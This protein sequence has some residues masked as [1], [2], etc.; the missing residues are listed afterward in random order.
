MENI[1]FSDLGSDPRSKMQGKR[2]LLLT[3]EELPDATAALAFS[4]LEDILVAVDHRG[5]P[6]DEGLWM[7]AIHL[8]LVSKNIDTEALRAS[9]GIS[10]VIATD[11]PME[12]HL[13]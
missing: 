6:V 5:L 12:H 13:W 11:K 3:A 9:S 7:R 2:W 10:K 1:V 4:E 8:L